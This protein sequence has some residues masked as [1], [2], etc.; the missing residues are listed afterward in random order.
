MVGCGWVGPRASHLH[1]RG[2]CEV[3]GWLWLGRAPR[4]TPACAWCMRAK[5]TTTTTT[6]VSYNLCPTRG[7]GTD[8]HAQYSCTARTALSPRHVRARTSR[9]D[10]RPARALSHSAGSVPRHTCPPQSQCTARSRPKIITDARRAPPECRSARYGTAR[11]PVQDAA[12]W[13]E[14]HTDPPAAAASS[15]RGDVCGP[16]G[17]SHPP[18]TGPRRSPRRAASRRPPTTLRRRAR[19]QRPRWQ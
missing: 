6:R 2:V 11:R 18:T 9:Q 3:Y 1:A 10:G 15:R 7:T 17:A 4:I 5:L 12:Q 14:Q 19:A 8:Q 13:R 16:R